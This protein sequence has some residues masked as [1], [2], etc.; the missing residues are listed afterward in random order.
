MAE[1]ET[2][3]QRLRRLLYQKKK[4]QIGLAEYIPVDQ[5]TV[6][7]WVHDKGIPESYNMKKAAEYLG[8]TASELE[9]G[10]QP[11]SVQ[12]APEP[13]KVRLLRL[14]HQANLDLAELSRRTHIEENQIRRYTEKGRIPPLK[15][16]QRI[17]SA[18]HVTYEYLV[19]GSR[20]MPPLSLPKTPTPEPG[21]ELAQFNAP[22]SAALNVTL[23][24]Y[25]LQRAKAISH[26][27]NFPLTDDQLAALAADMYAKISKDR[28]LDGEVE[29][30][31]IKMI[32]FAKAGEV[33]KE[34]SPPKGPDTDQ[35][36]SDMELAK[37]PISG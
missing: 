11:G 10:D 21:K 27:M 36:R 22:T 37:K 20:S 6:S 34:L 23:L 28:S 17:A 25:C 12:P 31:M 26:G 8:V 19:F 3:G 5:G 4:T 13:I 1:A 18:L 32:R 24:A 7:R 29:E 15:A 14:M 16:A 35:E 33:R 30:E 9:Y 2:F